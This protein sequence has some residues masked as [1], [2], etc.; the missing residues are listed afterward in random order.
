LP[1][2]LSA[3]ASLLGGVAQPRDPLGDKP[4]GDRVDLAVSEERKCVAL[5]VA[6]VLNAGVI[7][8]PATA[9]ALVAG[10]PLGSVLAESSAS[11]L[12]LFELAPS[13]RCLARTLQ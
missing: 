2:L 8:E 1:P 7:G 13:A 3:L 11:L 9:V 12:D 5:E 6:P 10:D 4:R